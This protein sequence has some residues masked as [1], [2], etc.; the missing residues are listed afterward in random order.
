MPN[1]LQLITSSIQLKMPAPAAKH[2]LPRLMKVL[3]AKATLTRLTPGLDW[4]RLDSSSIRGLPPAQAFELC[5]R[6]LEIEGVQA[7]EPG[8]DGVFPTTPEIGGEEIVV[9]RDGIV[10]ITA[11]DPNTNDKYSWHVEQVRAKCARR[12]FHVDGHG[13]RVAHLDTGYTLHPELVTGAAIRADLGYNFEE[14]KPSPIEPLK[15]IDHGHGTAT[16]SV[17]VGIEGRQHTFPNDNSFVEGVAPG[18]ELVPMRVDE[19]V[20]FLS[21]DNDVQAIGRAI[22]KRCHVISMSRSGLDQGALREAIALAKRHGLIVVAAAGNCNLGCV[23]RSPAN[24]DSVV[25]AVGSTIAKRSWDDSSRGREATIGAP[26]HSVYRARAFNRNNRYAYSV[27]RSSGTSYATP[28][29]AGAAA[30]WIELH[31]GTDAIARKIGGLD[32]VSVVFKHLLSTQGFQPGVDWDVND[33]G[34]G[35]LDCVALLSA[36]L[37]P[38]DALPEIE[39]AARKLRTAHGQ[40]NIQVFLDRVIPLG[41]DARA[42]ALMGRELE[43]AEFQTPVISKLKSGGR[44][45]E[46]H[47]LEESLKTLRPLSLSRQLKKTLWMRL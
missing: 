13:T 45:Y 22:E 11:A 35:I 23:I 26:A 6:L 2:S 9:M 20:W 8:F 3:R 4:Y 34:P 47:A 18:A 46:P 38:P 14:G 27:E 25:C 24:Y 44:T 12:M 33:Y 16:A 10:S 36:P 43:A 7:L 1:N 42:I 39:Q 17:L 5:Y 41:T 15:T 28:I 40:T 19:N 37:P 21:S 31:G 29:V 32:R 30:L